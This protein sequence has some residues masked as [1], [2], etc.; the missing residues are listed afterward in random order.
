MS[1]A[2]DELHTL[3]LGDQ[4]LDVGA[5]GLTPVRDSIRVVQLP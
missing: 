2:A 3:D 1:W 5:R 4:R